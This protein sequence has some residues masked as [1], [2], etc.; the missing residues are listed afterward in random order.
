MEAGARTVPARPDPPK[1]DGERRV[2]A[3][4][5]LSGTIG[6]PGDKS[7]AHR[8]ALFAAI[9]KGESRIEGF[10]NGGDPLSTLRCLRLL[11]AD[12]EL[13]EA[14]ATLIVRGKGLRGLSE[15][16][17]VLDCGNSG[18][19]MRLLS[20]LLS[21]QRFLSI[22]TG[23]ASLRSRP[24][25]RVIDPLD[26]MGGEL[27]SRSGGFAPIAIRGGDIFG[28]AHVLPVASAQV[29]SAL[30]LA[31]LYASSRTTVT[32]PEASRDHTERMLASMGAPLVREGTTTHVEAP[33][34]ELSPLALR[35]PGDFSTAAFW[36]VAATCVAGS[37]L[38][39]KDVGVN[40]TR[41]GA[42]DVL[43]EMGADIEVLPEQHA[44]GEPM[45]DVR[46]RASRL[47]GVEV[48]GAI[49]PRLIDEV[50]VLALAAT[51]A[52]GTTVF[53]NAAE[54]RVKESDRIATT[55]SELAK[56]GADIEATADGMIVRGTPGA[57]TGAAC[58]AHGDHRLALTLAVAGLMASGETTITGADAASVS[59]P[60]FWDEL[61][62][63]GH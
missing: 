40:P 13:N 46:V 20:G 24:M 22:L 56:L 14:D 54:L 26:R 43:R 21:G 42:L 11:G 47:H 25:S 33:Q 63:L 31:G 30:L 32:E 57:L 55:V 59:Y 39:L 15:P 16:A 45:A 12:L 37:K 52:E 38:L 27:H 3:R 62:A 35:I 1:A 49:V 51:Q 18:T 2:R 28:V 5:P 19:T 23:D 50:P 60:G 53:R 9:A 34:G 29:K 10:P 4:G 48:G 58:D 61:E 17:D 36:L 41:T 6:V 44:G 7:I 8:A